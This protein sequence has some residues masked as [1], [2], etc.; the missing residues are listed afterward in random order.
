MAYRTRVSSPD[1]AP[2]RA[3]LFDFNGTLSDDEPLLA[4]I[5]VRIFGEV[6]IEVDEALYLDVLAGYSDPEIIERV[7]RDRDRYSTELH[8]R[9]LERRSGLYLEAVAEHPPVRP[10][11]AEFAR[12]VAARVPVAVVSGAAR[13]EIEAVLAAAGLLELFEVIVSA[14]DVAAGKPDPEG[15]LRGLE[16]LNAGGA[17]IPPA[18]VLVFE[19]SLQGLAAARAAGMRC[20]VVVGT[21][22]ADRAVAADAVVSKLDWS[23]PLVKGWN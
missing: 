1:L 19:D 11:A 12:R 23:R 15:F 18:A 8:A 20:V 14:E 13:V 7:L 3:V 10:A 22:D 16:L 2:P 21:V 4:R 6:G 17:G 5:F 9:L